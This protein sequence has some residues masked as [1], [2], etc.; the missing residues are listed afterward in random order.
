MDTLTPIWTDYDEEADILYLR[1]H[2]DVQDA[3]TQE[4]DHGVLI[5]RDATTGEVVGIEI[6]DFLG[7]FV[8]LPHLSWLSDLG[9]SPEVLSFLRQKGHELQHD[10]VA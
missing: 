8:V 10:A 6:L 9:I 4:T 7:H 2:P 5:D 1:L 3:R